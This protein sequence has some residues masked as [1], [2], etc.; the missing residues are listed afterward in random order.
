MVLL[1]DYNNKHL[2]LHTSCVICRLVSAT[3][4]EKIEIAH[5][6]NWELKQFLVQF[7]STISLNFLRRSNCRFVENEV[8][9]CRG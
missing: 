7:I 9:K 5:N 3:M 6:L 1:T 2:M 8:T 4:M